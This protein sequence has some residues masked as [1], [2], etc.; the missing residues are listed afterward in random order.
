MDSPTRRT[1]GA[2]ASSDH[3]D[4]KSFKD[5]NKAL[6]DAED[7]L[8]KMHRGADDV[9]GS[10]KDLHSAHTKA[11]KAQIDAS[12]DSTLA[13][14]A[15]LNRVNDSVKNH[16][17]LNQAMQ[18]Q[19]KTTQDLD[20]HLQQTGDYLAEYA[21]QLSSASAASLDSIK[22]QEKLK[23][24][25]NNLNNS[26]ELSAGV[27][28]M[29]AKGQY[30]AAARALDNEAKNAHAIQDSIK[31]TTTGFN[32]FSGFV[33]GAGKGV[34]K[35]LNKFGLGAIAELTSI[36]AAGEH[37]LD[38]VKDA[39]KD[40]MMVGSKG[41]SAEF[42]KLSRSAIA[43]GISLET[44]SDITKANMK[45]IGQMS[46]PGFI[47][48]LK[49]SQDALM[50]L[51]LT[52]EEAAKTGAIL[53]QNA[54]L[55][56]VDIKSKKALTRSQ[57]DQIKQYETLRATTG[58]SIEAIA[59]Q[60]K[61]LL[62]SDDAQTA[63]IGMGKQ[64]RTLLLQSINAERTRLTTMGLTNEAALEV[65]KA[66]HQIGAEKVVDRVQD[67]AKVQAAAANL[68]IDSNIAQRGVRAYQM[69][70]AQRAADPEAQKDLDTLAKAFSQKH[71]ELYGVNSNFG[72]QQRWDSSAAMASPQ[73]MALV[74]GM[75]GSNLDRG[76]NDKQVERN[77]E[78]GRRSGFSVGIVKAIEES[79]KAIESPLGKIVLGVAAIA[80]ILGIKRFGLPGLG[81]LRER[82]G[83]GK[84]GGGPGLGDV[85]G[86]IEHGAEGGGGGLG[87]AA[88]N[89]VKQG[90][91][92]GFGKMSRKA[93]DMARDR[94]FRKTRASDAGRAAENAESIGSQRLQDLAARNAERTQG[95]PRGAHAPNEIPPVAEAEATGV[96]GK[97][98][99]AL[100]PLKMLKPLAKFAGKAGGI[101]SILT[102]AWDLGSLWT[103]DEATKKE[104]KVGTLGILGGMGGGVGGAEAG[105]LAGTAILPGI[106]TVIGAIGGGIL[107]SILGEKGGRGLGNLLTS[108]DKDN[109]DDY[110]RD[111]D[112]EAEKPDA[113]PS[114]DDTNKVQGVPPKAADSTAQSG[115][116][117]G[118]PQSDQDKITAQNA[119][120][121]AWAHD[122][123]DQVGK[124]QMSLPDG[125]SIG[126]DPNF[127]DTTKGKDGKEEKK[128]PSKS[129]SLLQDISDG[130]AKLIHLTGQGNDIAQD[131]N[132]QQQKDQKNN[133]VKGKPAPTPSIM[134]ALNFF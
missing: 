35:V 17:F 123:P 93:K 21:D 71:G 64:Q 101:A 12:K 130:I 43:L 48:S 126:V 41:F 108:G 63:M 5:L 117:Q 34:S 96:M 82:I 31:R 88:G 29:I 97:L 27:Q 125:S 39:Y 90:A 36:G 102:G 119:A 76:L 49:D 60:T 109:A 77:K 73:F 15:L 80:A 94:A 69:T 23:K 75:N 4:N 87:R 66:M 10:M 65:V 128:G 22:D 50:K 100:G 110:D 19:I 111:D 52:P 57:N 32:K 6:K 55:A 37:I 54:F 11:I 74:N 18:D 44:L 129:E 3:W 70:D 68:G 89:A 118:Q 113:K 91:E 1:G 9:S 28:E 56:G 98:G 61:A 92:S 67:S 16:T 72:D 132:S 8:D 112:A 59:E 62:E 106:G 20:K 131:A 58:E 95:I 115:T 42:F 45:Q 86:G 85:A 133:Q 47:Q 103:D 25:L 114:K 104:K 2:R 116:V 107:G 33:T 83:L 30:Q 26:V 14:A 81:R 105:A 24:A 122:H 124:V 51:G 53:N 40:Y 99:K 78:M 7:A 121:T 127:K 134:D 13:H 79:T 38:G 84:G 120:V 46:L